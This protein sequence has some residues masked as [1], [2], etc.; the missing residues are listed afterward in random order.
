MSYEGRIRR[1]KNMPREVCEQMKEGAK[2]S[3]VKVYA[4]AVVLKECAEG[5]Y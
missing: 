5:A 3:K 2:K 1:R 4:E